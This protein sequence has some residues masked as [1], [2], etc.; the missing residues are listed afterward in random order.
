VNSGLF[1][2]ILA[3]GLISIRCT[4]EKI[5]SSQD[6]LVDARFAPKI[7]YSRPALN[8]SGPYEPWGEYPEAGAR[9]YLRFNKLMDPVSVAKGLI[10][11]SSLGGVG[12]FFYNLPADRMTEDF[13]LIT[14]DSEL[15]DWEW[16]PYYPRFGEVLT[17]VAENDLKDINGNVIHPGVLGTFVPEPTFRVQGATP[18]APY[19]ASRNDYLAVRFNSPVDSS[20]LAAVSVDPPAPLSWSSATHGSLYIRAPLVDAAP[21]LYTLTVAAGARDRSGHVTTVP[22]TTEFR[23]GEDPSMSRQP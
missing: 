15:S 14:Y 5:I 16:Y 6:A 8:S 10:L 18:R 20:V 22:Y 12:A 17:I 11:R 19:T 7:L 9:F 3:L 1:L 13:I 23:V 4:E 2:L 21:G